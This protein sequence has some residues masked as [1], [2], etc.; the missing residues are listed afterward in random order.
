VHTN[1]DEVRKVK[2]NGLQ[3]KMNEEVQ[4]RDIGLKKAE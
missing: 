2:R 1:I 4:V 3:F